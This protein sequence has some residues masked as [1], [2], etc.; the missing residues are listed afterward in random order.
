MRKNPL[1]Y[2]DHGEIEE[3]A[4]VIEEPKQSRSLLFYFII[5]ANSLLVVFVL[6]VIW[7][8]F[9]KSPDIHIQNLTDRF[10][11]ASSISTQKI[12]EPTPATEKTS[13]ESSAI[14]GQEETQQTRLKQMRAQKELAA[15]SQRLERLRVTLEAEK[16]AAAQAKARSKPSEVTNQTQTSPLADKTSPVLPKSTTMKE[17]AIVP[18]AASE[19]KPLQT[20]STS[21]QVDKI[22]ET[23]KNQNLKKQ[24]VENDDKQS[25]FKTKTPIRIKPEANTAGSST[26]IIN[27]ELIGQ[28]L[29]AIIKSEQ[30]KSEVFKLLKQTE[31]LNEDTQINHK[32]SILQANTV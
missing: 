20:N 15:E 32:L 2:S 10:F 27:P 31:N 12:A 18:N 17:P 1:L 3:S 7:F 24:A 6:G 9:L 4:A 28:Q 14:Q 8:L 29:E 11:G 30:L 16:K 23:L 5:L 21:S 26:Q 25:Q 13:D 19:T 22:M